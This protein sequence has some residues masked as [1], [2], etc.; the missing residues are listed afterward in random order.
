[1]QILVTGGSGRL[2]G[3]LVP[4]L[5]AA[6]HSVRIL[7]RVQ[8]KAPDLQVP[9]I[10]GD[11]TTGAGLRDAVGDIDV[12][13]HAASDSRN[14]QAVDVEGTRRLVDVARSAGVK[15][16]VYVSIVGIDR[17][18]FAYYER[19]LEAERVIAESGVPFSILRATQFHSFV[20][21]LL[22]EA[23]RFPFVMPIPS[24]FWVQS[25]DVADI[26][27]RLS[28]AI[29]DGPRGPLR[30][31][32]GPEVL[33][34]EEAAAQW[35]QHRPAGWTKVAVPIHLPGQVAAAFC[36]AHNTC[37]TGERGAITWRE[38][39]NRSL[40]EGGASLQSKDSGER[41]G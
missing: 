18:P 17:I 27:A 14:A 36:A 3:T 30:D 8:R 16:L 2:G 37:P 20:A 39:L 40:D 32:G 10:V 21:F 23:S 28:R 22:N 35:L 41:Q 34:I 31:F 4:L 26:A 25:V 29:D 5:S 24:G 38:W 7:S 19:K 6:R 11:L 12:I 9:C 13:V 1:V 15:H 33:P